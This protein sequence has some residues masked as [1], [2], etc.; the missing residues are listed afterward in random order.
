MNARIGPEFAP[1]TYHDATNRNGNY[2]GD[3]MTEFQLLAANAQFQ[4]RRGKQWTFEGPTGALYQLDY[5]L[6]RKKW[7]NSVLNAEAYNSFCSVGSTHRVVCAKIQLSVR[8][9]KQAK[10]IRYDWK[11]FAASPDL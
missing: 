10:K 9:A 11:R 2:L 4:K 7:R 5:I 8:T 6:V 1:H 3:I